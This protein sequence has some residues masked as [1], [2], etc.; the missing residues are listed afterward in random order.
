MHATPFIRSV[1]A[2]SGCS[3]STNIFHRSSSPGKCSSAFLSTFCF[4]KTSC[5]FSEAK[6]HNFFDL[7]MFCTA[8]TKNALIFAPSY[9]LAASNQ[10]SSSKGNCSHALSSIYLASSSFPS[11]SSTLAAAYQPAALFGFVFI[12]AFS[13]ILAFF[14]SLISPWELTFIEFKSVM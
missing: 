3:S 5:S 9:S 13:N 2:Y 8:F 12:R 6:I 4:N 1:L 7:G 14:K 10:I 11:S